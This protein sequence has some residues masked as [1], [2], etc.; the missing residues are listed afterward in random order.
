MAAVPALDLNERAFQDGFFRLHD[1][2]LARATA[3]LRRLRSLDWDTL[4]GHKGFRWEAIQGT[5][6]PK[7]GP[8]YS[9][10]LTQRIRVLAYRDGELLRLLSIHPDHDSAYTG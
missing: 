9:L 2:D 10:R 3:A 5:Q 7:G 4:Y 6:A 1:R 8:V